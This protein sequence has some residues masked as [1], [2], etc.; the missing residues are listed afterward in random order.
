MASLTTQEDKLLMMGGMF[1]NIIHQFKQPLN[2]I[3]TEATGLKFQKEL[4]MLSDEEFE[5]SLNGIIKST[6]YLAQTIDDFRNFLKEDKIKEFFHIEKNIELI[7]SIIKPIL[8]SKGIEIIKNFK[9]KN[10]E[11]EGYPREFAQVIINILNNAKDAI[12]L[13]DNYDKIILIEVEEIDSHLEINIFDNGGGIPEDTLPHIFDSHFTTKESN[14]GTGIGLHM[15]KII[16]N[17]HFKGSLK[18][19]NATFS[20]HEK[21]Y[22]GAC[23]TINVPKSS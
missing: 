1:E 8:K 6:N 20:L 13:N 22:Y 5:E 2:A 18:A 10:L 16:I 4:G 14:G 9:S 7:E 12:L 21:K 17:E 19:T 11:I 3:N 23:F 15:S